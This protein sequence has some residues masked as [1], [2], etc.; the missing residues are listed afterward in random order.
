MKIEWNSWRDLRFETNINW[1]QVFESA[2]STLPPMALLMT[3]A[4]KAEVQH[5]LDEVKTQEEVVVNLDSDGLEVTETRA[6]PT[7]AEG[8]VSKLP[9]F[10]ADTNITQAQIIAAS[11]DKP[12]Q[13][14]DFEIG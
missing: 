9:V 3:D 13:L 2:N 11:L 10:T 4:Q 1:A 7:S 14:P 5:L 6:T 8:W 12:I